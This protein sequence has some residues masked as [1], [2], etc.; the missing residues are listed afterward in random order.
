MGGVGIPSTHPHGHG[1]CSS[2]RSGVRG[3][4]AQVDGNGCSIQDLHGTARSMAC[5][6]WKSL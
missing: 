4:L 2:D 6:Q 1:S 3:R 5:K